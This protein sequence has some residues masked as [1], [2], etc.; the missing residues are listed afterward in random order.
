M[1]GRQAPRVAV[2]CKNNLSAKTKSVTGHEETVGIRGSVDRE[3][4]RLGGGRDGFV[5]GHACVVVRRYLRRD[6]TDRTEIT[7]EAIDCRP[8]GWHIRCHRKGKLSQGATGG[9]SRWR[10][11]QRPAPTD[12]ASSTQCEARQ[13]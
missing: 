13:G 5:Q 6:A 7:D 8:G 4:Y 9:L 2:E 12:S 1:E 3:I 11:K 10:E